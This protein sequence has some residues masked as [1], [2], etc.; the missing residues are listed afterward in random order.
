MVKSGV[1]PRGH[2]S[3]DTNRQVASL[4]TTELGK[5]RSSELAAEESIGLCTLRLLAIR[6]LQP[7]GLQTV[8]RCQETNASRND[9]DGGEYTYRIPGLLSDLQLSMA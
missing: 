2:H 9:G 4:V 3:A 5:V 7:V 6:D 8:P 1:G